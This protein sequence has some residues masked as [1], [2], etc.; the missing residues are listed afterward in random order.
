M[1]V[2]ALACKNCG[3]PLQI[4]AGM[5][6]L[7]CASCGSQMRVELGGGTVSLDLVEA[8]GAIRTGSVQAAAE[9]ALV[10]LQG[11]HDQAY[12]ATLGLRR[13]ISDLEATLASINRYDEDTLT[14]AYRN[15]ESIKTKIS[16][17][18]VLR[19][20]AV[21]LALIVAILRGIQL[22]N[23]AHGLLEASGAVIVILLVGWFGVGVVA[24]IAGQ[25]FVW[26]FQEPLANLKHKVESY[27][28]MVKARESLSDVR[29]RLNSARERLRLS[30]EQ[31]RLEQI[32][33]EIERKRSIVK[34]SSS[35]G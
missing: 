13:D 12:V 32:N 10:R 26:R 20:L 22:W 18:R 25:V 5:D 28:A 19:F 35:V 11:E 15:A 29:E 4:K 21:S 24:L 14:A 17:G 7:A 2:I 33:L 9:L 1:N 34:Q 31:A 8:V 6:Q 23:S 16:N 27:H 3:A 30:P